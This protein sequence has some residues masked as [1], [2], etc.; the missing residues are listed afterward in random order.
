MESRELN[1]KEKLEW[2]QLIRSENIGPRTFFDLLKFY[3]SPAKAV[4]AIPAIAAKGGRKNP[5]KL[6]TR[7]E[8][9]KEIESCE[10]LDAKIVAFCEPWYPS[11]LRTIDDPPPV[12]TVLGNLDLLQKKSIGVVGTRNASANS[13]M[14]TAKLAKDLGRAGYVVVSGLA[15][16]IDTAAHRASLETGTVAVIAGGIDNIYPPE[17]KKLY[18]EIA[19]RG[20]IISELPV[21]TIPRAQNF[22]QRNRIIAG[23][24]EG[25]VVTEAALKS[26]SLITARL[27]TEYGREVFAVPGF[28]LDPR[29]QG[30]N[31]LLKNGA[32]L[33]ESV[34]DVVESLKFSS[35]K[36]GMFMAEENVDY[37]SP[38]SNLPPEED[39]EKAKEIIMMKL[40]KSPIL[41]DDLARESELAVKVVLATVLELELAGKIERHPG[42]RLSL[43]FEKEE[44][45]AVSG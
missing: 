25:V 16:G 19:T 28:P 22:P 40:S 30:N 23:I 21:G 17:N 4:A 8:A 39:I 35:Q 12:I 32:T 2:L 14:F 6:C 5:I 7:Q 42:G 24:S 3:G 31:R 18:E 38:V 45:S 26:G 29:S 33:T 36:N 44:K 34:E 43:L 20:A 37:F 27:A 1:E 9:E 11:L 15:R 13:S 41:V 10:K